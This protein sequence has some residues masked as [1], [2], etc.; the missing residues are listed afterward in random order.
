MTTFDDRKDAYENKYAHD[1]EAEFKIL[2]RRNKLLGLWAAEKLHLKPEEQEAYAKEVVA[3][4]FEE[5]GDGDVVRKVKKDFENAGIQIE[6]RDIQE[7]LHRL[8]GVA[9]EQYKNP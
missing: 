5:P 9:R 1:Q 8:H 3:A 7:Q 6:E 2:A 4:D